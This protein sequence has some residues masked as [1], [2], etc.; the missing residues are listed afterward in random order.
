MINIYKIFKICNN[1]IILFI[2]TK[3]L[4]ILRY[5]LKINN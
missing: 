5:L 3:Y 4:K 2:K 1:I